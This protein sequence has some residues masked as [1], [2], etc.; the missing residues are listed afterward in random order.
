MHAI[1]ILNHVCMY[2]QLMASSIFNTLF[3][4]QWVYGHTWDVKSFSQCPHRGNRVLMLHFLRLRV[5]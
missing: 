1:S 4:R 2:G 3:V 5:L